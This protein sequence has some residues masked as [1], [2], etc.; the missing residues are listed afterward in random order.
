[1][2]ANDI[3]DLRRKIKESGSEYTVA[4]KTLVDVA[5]ADSKI[6]G[7]KTKEMEGEV[8]TVFGYEDEVAP[9]K[10]LDEFKKD[11]DSIEF[12]GGV[13][14]NKFIDAVQVQALAKMPS[15]SEL[16]AKLVGSIKSP[17]S[18]LIRCWVVSAALYF[19]GRSARKASNN[20]RSSCSVERLN[21][22][23]IS[24]LPSA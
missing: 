1:M 19:S 21:R 3:N 5:F 22:S 2:G 8:A 9:A 13:L 18:G 24:F 20:W 12:M 11:H 16:Y 4:K 14:E 7:L 15:K 17:I 23:C 6:D 10:I